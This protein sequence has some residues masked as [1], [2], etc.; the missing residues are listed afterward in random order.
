MLEE[1]KQYKDFPFEVS[2]LGRVRT[3]QRVV[4]YKDGREYNYSSKIINNI[5]LENIVILWFHC[6]PKHIILECID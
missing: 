5:L 1:W 4:K 3:M 6:I 2:T